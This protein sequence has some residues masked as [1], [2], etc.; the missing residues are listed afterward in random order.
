M[1]P[2]NAGGL[3]GI[4]Q[5]PSPQTILEGYKHGLFTFAHYGPLKW[6]SLSERCVLFFDEFHIA[7]NVRR[8]LRQRRYSVTFDRDFEGVIKAC[9]ARRPGRWHLTWITPRIMRLYTDLF[10]AGHA[11][12]IEVWNRN[13]D[14]VGGSFGLGIGRVFFGESQFTRESHTSKIAMAVLTWHLAKWDFAFSDGKWETGSMRDMGFRC[15][16]R[17]EFLTRVASEVHA[18]GRVGRWHVETDLPTIA[19]WTPNPRERAAHTIQTSLSQ[20]R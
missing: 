12:S 11:H 19:G 9:A 5:S 20:P 14:L 17:E 15:I 1:R 10:D 7:T 6:L 13:G 3:C 8:I 16:P 2:V 18:P 4:V